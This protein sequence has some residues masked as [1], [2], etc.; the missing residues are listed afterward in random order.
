[1]ALSISKSSSSS[2]VSTVRSWT[3]PMEFQGQLYFYHTHNYLS[4]FKAAEKKLPENNM[5]MCETDQ[6]VSITFCKHI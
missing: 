6:F 3:Q 1:M 4:F 5:M 2:S